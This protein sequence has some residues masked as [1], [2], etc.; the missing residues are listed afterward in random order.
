MPKY[1]TAALVKERMNNRT[2]MST[3]AI[4]SIIDHCEGYIDLTLKIPSTF[5]FD[6]TKA[7]HLALRR[8]ASDMA[9][10]YVLATSSMSFQTLNQAGMLA[11]ILWDNI[12]AQFKE[13]K[14]QD[15]WNFIEGY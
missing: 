6:S 4:E 9:A 7:P 5:T 8:L 11:D 12:N 1:T 10:L 15:Y 3:S 2:A 13:L 14:D